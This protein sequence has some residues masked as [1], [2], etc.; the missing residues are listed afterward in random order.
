M[1]VIEEILEKTIVLV[2][3]GCILCLYTV[4]A[5][6]RD[7]NYTSCEPLI[8]RP[9]GQMLRLIENAEARHHIIPFNV[10]R[11]FFQ[12]AWNMLQNDP[13]AYQSSG[14]PNFLYR[15]VSDVFDSY[16]Q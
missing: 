3:I 13:N 5:N 8:R 1:R 10:M 7:N 15:Y 6:D 16:L 14:L 9:G 12:G 2:S 4:Q 11:R